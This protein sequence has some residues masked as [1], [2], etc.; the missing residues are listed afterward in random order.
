VTG[1]PGKALFVWRPEP[2]PV[3]TAVLATIGVLGLGAA[4]LAAFVL[5]H[6]PV[7]FA[8]DFRETPFYG[9]NEAST[10][11]STIKYFF[12]ARGQSL[13]HL[14]MTAAVA[15]LAFLGMRR[16]VRRDLGGGLGPVLVAVAALTAWLFLPPLKGIAYVAA[17]L[18]L[19]GLLALGRLLKARALNALFATALLA[20]L[21]VVTLPG[22]LHPPDYTRVPWWEV[23]YGQSH[24]ALVVAPADLLGAGRVLLSEVRPDY[25]LVLPVLV[26]GYERRF[27]PLTFGGEVRLLLALQALYLAL[28]VWLFARR[29]RGRFVFALVAFVTVAPWFH[30]A[31]KGLRFPNQTPWRTIGMALALAILAVLGGRSRRRAAFVLG[32]TS[33]GALFVNFES[34]VA[35]TV[36]CLV[37]ACF[38]FGLLGPAASGHDRLESVAQFGLGLLASTAAVALLVPLAL[39]QPLDLLRLPQLVANA[40]FT[41]SAGFS[42]WPLTADPWPVV[43]FG[44]AAFVLLLAGFRGATPASPRAAF[45]AATAALLVVW[46]AYYANRPHPWNLSSYYLPYGVLLIDLLRWVELRVRR[47]R[48]SPALVAAL[49]LLASVILPNLVFQAG[50]GARQ[51]SAALGPALRG[52]TPAGGRRLSGVWLADPGARELEERARFIREKAEAEGPPIYLTSDSYL[53]PKLS[54]VFSA[55]PVVDFCWQ[56]TTRRLY[57]GVLDAVARSD[58]RALYLDAPGTLTYTASSCAVF[59]DKVRD[60]LGARFERTGVESGWEVWRRRAETR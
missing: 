56:A 51:V 6:H 9:P 32:L 28:A 30:F 57:E 11:L 17:I 8:L 39:G 58:R 48:V 3:G 24:Y 54:G 44:H 55:L 25:G 22:F 34:G 5:L 59:Y 53:V 46:F 50:K 27:G 1:S 14:A 36:A 7:P 47:R 49:A 21:A 13:A 26:G 52:A 12:D 16:G 4:V 33:G 38:R 20:S 40:A 41:A 19:A 23:G 45:R 29:A 15:L 35:V 31:H 37:W 60:D 2:A 10:H 43:M 42:G 18:L